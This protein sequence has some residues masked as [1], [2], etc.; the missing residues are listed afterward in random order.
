MPSLVANI[1]AIPLEKSS[2]A[3]TYSLHVANVASETL[4]N[5]A[6]SRGVIRPVAHACV[7]I[8][9]VTLA[10]LFRWYRT[11]QRTKSVQFKLLTAL[12]GDQE[13]Y[14]SPSATKDFCPHIGNETCFQYS[15]KALV[16]KFIYG[17]IVHAGFSVVSAFPLLVRRPSKL[18]V[19]LQDVNNVKF[20]SF[21]ASMTAIYRVNN[22]FIRF[23]SCTEF[24]I[25]INSSVTTY[26]R[27][28]IAHCAGRV[29]ARVIQA[30]R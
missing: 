26:D 23:L 15:L 10:A 25:N 6:V 29:A 8:M 19:L 3:Q 17:W 11:T 7:I 21:L 16:T 1:I 2:R 14:T 4:Y 9:A 13:R 12:I 5:M 20:G 18:S 22:H 27:P 30:T 24:V 28:C